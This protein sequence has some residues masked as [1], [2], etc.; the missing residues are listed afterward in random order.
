MKAIC[1]VLIAQIFMYAQS[2]VQI[3]AIRVETY[4]AGPKSKV[5]STSGR[6]TLSEKQPTYI[7]LDKDTQGEIYILGKN[8]VDFANEQDMQAGSTFNYYRFE[9]VK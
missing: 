5:F 4:Q 6:F 1:H 3:T 2:Y 8:H 7:K 9:R